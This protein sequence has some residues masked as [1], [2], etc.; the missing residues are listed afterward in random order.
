MSY[1]I[2]IRYK[3]YSSFQVVNRLSDVRSTE[4]R[5]REKKKAKKNIVVARAEESEVYFHPLVV[6]SARVQCNEE[7]PGAGS[8]NGRVLCPG[9]DTRIFQEWLVAIYGVKFSDE[10]DTERD[11]ERENHKV[12]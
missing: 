2:A 9:R 6:K 4:Q 11:R 10:R 1:L 7:T 8:L 3:S 12:N 5:S